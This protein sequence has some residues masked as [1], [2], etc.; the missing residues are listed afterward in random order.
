[1]IKPSE[2]RRVYMK[3]LVKELRTIGKLSDAEAR[4][5]AVA[6]CNLTRNKIKHGKTI[7]FGFMKI[8]PKTIKPRMIKCNIAGGKPKDIH[9][10]ETVVWKVRVA[11][12]WQRKEQP[13]WSRYS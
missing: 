12:S 2:H 6:F 8:T 7:D 13:H 5:A 1:M 3:N 10:G 9:M 11:R 4:K